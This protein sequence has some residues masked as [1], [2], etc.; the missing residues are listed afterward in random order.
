MKQG[1]TYYFHEYLNGGGMMSTF[2][3]GFVIIGVAVWI[4][5]GKNGGENAIVVKIDF[6]GKQSCDYSFEYT[7]Q[8][9]FRQKDSTSLKS[10]SVRGVL[11][12]VNKQRKRLAIGVDSLAVTSDLWEGGLRKE[13]SDKI[14]ASDVI[15]SLADGFPVIDSMPAAQYME[16]D[17]YKQLAKLLPNLPVKAIY[18]GFTWERTVT[19]PLQT[20]RGKIPCEIYRFY[21]FTKLLGDSALIS[22]KIAYTASKKAANGSDVL[23]YIP[24]VGK[25][26]GTAVIDIRNRCLVRAEMNFA[27]P[28][29]VVGDI[30]VIWTEKAA[31]RLKNCN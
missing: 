30:S 16:W 22:W 2:L 11:S 17:L 13:I 7:S 29:A 1:T 6:N 23:R 20:V 5:S 21:T 3:K 18:P 19:L 31:I 26:A 4:V 15:L 10:S 28:V 8:G 24:V 9:S 12:L 25:G 27:A 14:L